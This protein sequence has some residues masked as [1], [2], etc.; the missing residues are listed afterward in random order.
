MRN[1]TSTRKNTNE[2]KASTKMLNRIQRKRRTTV[3]LHGA[4]IT[5]ERLIL[6]GCHHPHFTSIP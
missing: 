2:V 5:Q 6:T 3:I 1:Q 4:T